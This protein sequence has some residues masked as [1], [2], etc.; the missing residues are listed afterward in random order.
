MEGGNLLVERRYAERRVERLPA[1]ARELV[2]WR[3]DVIVAIG[4]SAVHA[5]LEATRTIPTVMVVNIDPV[6]DGLV[7]SLARPGGN[8]TGVTI[9]AEGTLA[10]KRLELLKEA[11]P[12]ASR[13]AFLAPNDPAVATQAAEARRAAT[14]LGITLIEVT[15]RDRDYERAFATIVHER[16]HAVF[17][18]ATPTFGNDRRRIRDLAATRKL[19]A[20]WEWREHVIDGGFIT[21]GSSLAGT[22]TSTR[23]SRAPTPPTCPSSS[24][25]NSSSSSNCDRRPSSHSRADSMVAER[26]TAAVA[27]N[28]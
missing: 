7:N 9:T 1:L 14:T 27:R 12:G 20:M 3:A 23:F 25:R 21:Y 24:R 19:P 8:L 26:P 2:E 4:A 6:T 13:I 11:V 10:G 15:V 5:V 18:A 16:A 17:V 28:R 22:S